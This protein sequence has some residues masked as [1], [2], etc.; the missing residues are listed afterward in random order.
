M[1]KNIKKKKEKDIIKTLVTA[2]LILFFIPLYV[3]RKMKEKDIYIIL[4]L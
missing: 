4:M 2:I 1:I 3:S